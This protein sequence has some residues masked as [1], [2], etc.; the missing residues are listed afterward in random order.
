M[1]K[2]L[3]MLF[4]IVIIGNTKDLN[5][6]IKIYSDP[7]PYFIVD[8]KKNI[9]SNKYLRSI[10]TKRV[11][12]YET[13]YSSRLHDCKNNVFKGLGS[14]ETLDGLKT[15]K[16]NDQ[17]IEIVEGSIAYEIGLIVCNDK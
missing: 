11:G 16:G 3:L 1:K 15:A 7:V 2:T 13:I 17:W 5:I 14:S 4:I 9:N 10:I 12:K 6:P 8:K